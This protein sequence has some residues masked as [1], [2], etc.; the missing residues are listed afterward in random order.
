MR[1]LAASIKLSELPE[2]RP[3][4]P[5]VLRTDPLE[6]YN[7][8]PRRIGDATLWGWGE[9]GR[10]RAVLKVEHMPDRPESTRWV[11]G[12]VSLA[13]ARITVEFVDGQQWTSKRSGV[14]MATIPHAPAPG[15]SDAVRIGQMR[16]L[17]RRFAASEYAGPVRGRLQLRLM[18]KPLAR[19]SDDRTGIQD[20]ALFAFAY[21]TNPD[22]LLVIESG[23]EHD[24][25]PAWHYGLA[26]LGGG[27]PLVTLDG[28]EVWSQTGADPPA[29]LETYMNRRMADGIV[30]Y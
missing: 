20:G 3:S 4:V 19:Y 5:V 7:D 16:T 29:Q 28:K 14:D 17:C 22:V 26:R 12:L 9:V 2:G 8:P 1:A 24:K 23:R 18:P 6:R 15:A 27:Q 25:P 21:G 30:P 13:P 11:L 10:P